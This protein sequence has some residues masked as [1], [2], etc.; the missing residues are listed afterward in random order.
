MYYDMRDIQSLTAILLPRMSHGLRNN[1]K[2]ISS[3]FLSMFLGL[4]YIEVTL[5]YEYRQAL[6]VC[7]RKII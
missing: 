3:V 4:W 5:R 6:V 1:L 2:G 7:P